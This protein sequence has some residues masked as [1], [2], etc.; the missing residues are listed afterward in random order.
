[1]TDLAYHGVSFPEPDISFD[2][3]GIVLHAWKKLNVILPGCL[4]SVVYK[5]ASS[6]CF[7]LHLVETQCLHPTVTWPCVYIAKTRTKH[8]KFATNTTHINRIDVALEAQNNFVGWQFQYWWEMAVSAKRE[9]TWAHLSNQHG[10]HNS[11]PGE[12]HCFFTG[13]LQLFWIT[14]N[15][16]I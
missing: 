16:S 15:V 12:A 13:K 5:A 9:P 8:G 7:P 10:V 14:H 2:L 6:R 1:M 11:G 3:W 4:T